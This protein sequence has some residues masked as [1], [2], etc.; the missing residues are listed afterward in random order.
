[1]RLV[2]ILLAASCLAYSQPADRP[3]PHARKS[4]AVIVSIGVALGIAFSGAAVATA[5]RPRPAARKR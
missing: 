2:F 4:I 1:M 5:K 3:D